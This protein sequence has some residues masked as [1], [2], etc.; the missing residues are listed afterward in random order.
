MFTAVNRGKRSVVLDAMSPVGQSALRRLLATADVFL[1]NYRQDAL[2]RLSVDEITVRAT[3]ERLVYAVA[4]GFGSTGPDAAKSMVDGSGQARGGLAAV[5]GHAGEQ[6]LTGAVVA[7]SAGGLLLALAVMTALVSRERYGVGQRVDTSALA[8]QLW[9]QSWELAHTSMTGYVPVAQGP[10]HPIFTG[11]YGLYRTADDRGLFIAN[12]ASPES[13]RAFCAF[14]EI[15]EACDDPRWDSNQKR[16]GFDPTVPVNQVNE[17]RPHI[18]AAVARRPLAEWETFLDAH[19]DIMFQRVQDYGEVLRD[20]QVVAN[21]YLADVEVFG[22]GS[23]R[24]VGNL[25]GLSKTPGSV[26]GGP[27]LLGQDTEAVLGEVGCSPKEVAAVQTEAANTL[28]RKPSKMHLK[29]TD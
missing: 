22:A 13:W 29:P 1:S 16:A 21:G 2:K 18:T 19:A 14:G 11:V 8:G 4:T 7:D 24:L 20:Q 9:L 5:T 17:L 15:T 23:H 6:T 27:P 25:V 3:N 28:V 10:H 26:K 12:I